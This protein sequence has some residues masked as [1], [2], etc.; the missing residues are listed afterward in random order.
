[1]FSISSLYLP[2]VVRGNEDFLKSNLLLFGENFYRILGYGR[3]H[4][5]NGHVVFDSLADEHTIKRI[6]KLGSCLDSYVLE[7]IP[8]S[9]QRG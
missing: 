2:R 3:I 1:M 5:H 7:L 9:A 4:S 8:K 6:T